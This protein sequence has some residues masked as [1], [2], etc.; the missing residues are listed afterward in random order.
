MFEKLKFGEKSAGRREEKMKEIKNATTC[1]SYTQCLCSD[2][3]LRKTNNIKRIGQSK[4][5][6]KNEKQINPTI[7]HTKKYK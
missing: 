4:K 6:T 2:T 5:K 7:E 3:G 1:L